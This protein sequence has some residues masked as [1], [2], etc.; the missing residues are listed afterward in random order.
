MIFPKR[1]LALCFFGLMLF[2]YAPII[3]VVIFSFHAGSQGVLWEGVSLRWYEAFLDDIRLIEALGTSLTIALVSAVLSVCIGTSAAV[4]LLRCAPRVRLL[5]ERI[6]MLPLLIPDIVLGILSLILFSL[7]HVTLGWL[8]IIF[9]HTVFCTA[10]VVLV[11]S[12]RL[13]TLPHSQERASYDLGASYWQYIRLVVLPQVRSAMMASLLL[14]F[15]LSLDDFTI[16]FFVAGSGVTTIPLRMYSMLRFGVNPSVH[17]LS[18][19]Q[20]MVSCLLVSL[21]LRFDSFALRKS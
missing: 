20:I 11:V 2:L 13:V 4:G 19:V 8:S 16:T 5:L 6:L 17:A 1:L 10:L 15:I 14:C 21:S 9:A 18:T 3:M 12:A 7:C